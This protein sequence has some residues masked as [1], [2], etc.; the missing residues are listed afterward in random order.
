MEAIPLMNRSA[1]DG[2]RSSLQYEGEGVP[3][4]PLHQGVCERHGMEGRCVK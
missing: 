4:H 1:K 2:T 3:I